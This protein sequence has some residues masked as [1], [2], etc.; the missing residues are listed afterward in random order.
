MNWEAI[1]AV[2]HVVAAGGVIASLLYLA[3]QVRQDNRASAVAAKLASTPLLSGFV[4]PLISNPELMVVWRKGRKDLDSLG[5]VE[6][7]RFANMCLKAFWFFSAAPFQLRMG[8]LREE[9]WAEFYGVIRFWIEGDG[10][11]TWWQRTEKARFG[12]SFATFID[13]EIA[14]LR[15]T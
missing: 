14:A 7:H 1:A 5:E 8:T 6:R 3:T 2:A 4:D 9:E 11:R 12:T 10:V 15:S 13:G